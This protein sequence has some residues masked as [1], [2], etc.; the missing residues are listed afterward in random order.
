MHSLA[1]SLTSLE[2]S[3]LQVVALERL[4]CEHHSMERFWAPP[5]DLLLQCPAVRLSPPNPIQSSV[6]GKQK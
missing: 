1:F 3:I 5:I 2:R 6:I 4:S